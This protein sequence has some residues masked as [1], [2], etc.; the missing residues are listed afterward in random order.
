MSWRAKPTVLLLLALH[1]TIRSHATMVKWCNGDMWSEPQAVFV[2]ESFE[3]FCMCNNSTVQLQNMYLKPSHLEHQVASTP[4]DEYTIK[5]RVEVDQPRQ[6]IRIYCMSGEDYLGEIYVNV[7]PTLNVTSFYCRKTATDKEASCFFKELGLAASITKKTYSLSIADLP[8]IPCFKG[9]HFSSWID[10]P[11]LFIPRD[12]DNYGPNY[13]IQLSMEYEG[14]NQSKVFPMTLREM[15]V[16]EWPM[17]QPKFSQSSSRICLKWAHTDHL[18]PVALSQNWRVEIFCSNPKIKPLYTERRVTPMFGQDLCFPK[19]PYANQGY[20]FRFRRRYNVTGAPWSTEFESREVTSV[21]D[22]PARPP[23]FL[24]NGF[25]HDPEKKEL[26]V[27]WRQLDEL[28]LNGPDFT[29]AAATGTGKNPSFID[30][31]CALFSDWDPTISGVIYVWSQNSVGT[32]NTSNVFEVPLLANSES[33]QIRGLRYHDDNYT[34][35]WQAP[36]EQQGLIGYA[37]SWCSGS[38]IRYQICDDQ[39]S[40]QIEMLERSQLLFQFNQ[41]KLLSNMAVAA[42]YKDKPSGGMSFVGTRFPSVQK[43]EQKATGLSLIQVVAVIILMVALLSLSFVSFRKLR[44]MAK[45]KVTLPDIL[46]KS[47]D[48]EIPVP[49]PPVSI[50]VPGNYPPNGVLTIDILTKECPVEEEAPPEQDYISEP[51]TPS[52]GSESSSNENLAYEPEPQTKNIPSP[53]VTL[54]TGYVRYPS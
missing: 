7:V 3:V 25:Y 32:S 2:G 30:S 53:Y 52:S 39:K 33:L 8:S 27:F 23:V 40:I 10:C 16:P 28:E 34:L 1:L 21:A 5:H 17:T 45:I 36:Q 51:P 44:K 42:S 13:Q 29:Y 15:T 9:A 48:I 37:I 4:V 49:G 11:G 20:I 26:Y 41:S 43:D 31:N 18:A 6:Y 12:S 50:T 19:L 24:T 35:T 47:V 54:G 22:I 14:H 46:F 38:T